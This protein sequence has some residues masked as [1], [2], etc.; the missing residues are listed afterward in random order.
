MECPECYSNQSR[1]TPLK[2]VK[3]CLTKHRQYICSTCGR[4]VCIDV[5]GEK[6]AR[7][8]YPFSSLSNAILYLKP[9]EI[10]TGELCGIYELIYKR[11]DIRFKIFRT[12]DDF[13]L[14]LKKNPNVK[15]KEKKPV[16]ISEKYQE[17]DSTQ[18]RY[19][20]EKEVEKYTEERNLVKFESRNL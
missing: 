4:V 9:A 8:F 17:I 11:G 3:E 19:L 7:Y 6:K 14:Y 10:I 20:T 15:S 5:K 1:I 13:E 2:G 12:Q 18:I 16:Y